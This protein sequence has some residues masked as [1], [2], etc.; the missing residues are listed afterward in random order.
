MIEQ[1]CPSNL[2]RYK[3]DL[4]SL[5]ATGEYLLLAMQRECSPAQFDKVVK[6]QYKDNGE[7]ILKTIPSFDD[8]Y[9]PWYSEAK[10]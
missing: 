9:Q 3:K 6:R 2:H 5:I 7:E 10:Y 4:D 1:E 8:S